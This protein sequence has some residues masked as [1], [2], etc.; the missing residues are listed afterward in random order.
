MKKNREI[1]EDNNSKK[2]AKG[3][4]EE[5]V[6]EPCTRCGERNCVAGADF[7]EE[8]LVEMLNTRIPFMGWVAGA[9]SLVVAVVAIAASVFLISPSIL[10]IRAEKAANEKNWNDA[11]F[12]YDQMDKTLEDFRNLIEWKENTPEPFLR[13]FFKLGANTHA[14]M[15]EAYTIMHGPL[16]AVDELGIYENSPLTKTKIAKPYWEQY[17]R[18]ENSVRQLFY[19]GRV[20]DEDTYEASIVLIDEVAK[21]E[22][23]DK[24]YIAYAKYQMAAV[25]YNQPVE[26]SYKW[27]TECD[28]LAKASDSDYKWMYYHDF[29]DIHNLMGNPDKAIAL[30]DELIAENR[31][32]F[33][34]YKHKTDIL[35]E[36]GR[37]KDAD[38]FVNSLLDE[39][40]NY[41]ETQEMQLKVA[42]CKG[43]Y[44]KVQV[45]GD[46]LMA[47]YAASPETYRQMAL[48]YLATGDYKRA[49]E[50]IDNGFSYC[51]L[52]NQEEDV[53]AELE[54]IQVVCYICAKLYEKNFELTD[55]EK[56]KVTNIYNMF[57]EDYKSTPEGAAIING[58]KDAH[59]ILT[60]GDY[61]LL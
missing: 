4:R 13:R 40:G 12:Y 17:V 48:M 16:A 1:K 38:K 42:R 47:D 43:E 8:C 53:S 14:K 19:S 28:K 34:A 21:G 59:E 9:A 6:T 25:Y 54:K 22:N 60:Q 58:E 31:N 10:C 44:D 26:V 50:Y 30:M 45:L 33:D 39:Y 35:L 24:V 3:T 52:L 7:C 55:S 11:V 36:N 61:D 29:A 51:N 57:A 41:A 18:I 15:F 2:K 46:A 27:I 20:P 5:V 37:L 56:Y 32:N 23:I 49:F